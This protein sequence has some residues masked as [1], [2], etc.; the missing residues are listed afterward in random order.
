MN[1]CSKGWTAR[2]ACAKGKRCK[3]ACGGENHGEAHKKQIEIEFNRVGQSDNDRRNRGACPNS[4]TR[5]EKTPQQV[6][7]LAAVSG[8]KNKVN[9]CAAMQTKPGRVG[10]NY[11]RPEIERGQL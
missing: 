10:P 7:Q 2:C 5:P 9:G 1:T 11:A 4:C 8:R 6:S 3:C